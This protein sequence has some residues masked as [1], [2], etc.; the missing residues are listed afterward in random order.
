M[1][2]YLEIQM[3]QININKIYNYL[4]L[5]SIENN[6]E[7]FNKLAFKWLKKKEYYVYRKIFYVIDDCRVVCEDSGSITTEIDLIIHEKNLVYENLKKRCVMVISLK[8]LF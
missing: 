8:I 4:Y 1:I 6:D 3:D 7:N 5:Y 2:F